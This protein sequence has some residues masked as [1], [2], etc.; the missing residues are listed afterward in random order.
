M[1]GALV[2][3]V[4]IILSVCAAVLLFLLLIALFLIIRQKRQIE[5]LRE[6]IDEFINNGTLTDFSVRDNSLAMLQ[7][8][9]SDLEHIITLERSNTLLETKKNEEFISDISHQLKT[10]IAGLRLY[11]EMENADSPSEYTEKELQLIERMENL[12]RE[13]LRLEKIKSAS[14]VMDFKFYDVKDIVEEM[15]SEFHHLF[16][17]KTYNV[18]G[19]SR[20]RCDKSWLSEAIGNIV[21]NASEHTDAD[22]VININIE[23]TNRST[24]IEI[25]DNGGGLPD[26]EIP[27]LFTRFYRTADAPPSGAGI[28]LAITKAIV[29]KHHGIISAENK[30]GGLTIS[31]CIP[32]IDG[33]EAIV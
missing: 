11:C 20:L 18:S 14:Y 6:S 30:N 17:S 22:G 33:Y 13:L 7:N 9:V 19:N 29:E 4:C 12:V 27:N 31:I 10:P 2:L 16:P 8:S 24:T 23:S 5:R 25:S 15:L 32:H 21:K 1:G 26:N 28:G 3:P